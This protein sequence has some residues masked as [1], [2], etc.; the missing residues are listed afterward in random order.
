M[1]RLLDG[2]RVIAPALLPS[3]LGQAPPKLVEASNAAACVLS[4]REREVLERLA[5]GLT[6]REIAGELYVGEETVKSHLSRLYGKLQATDRRD[7]VARA[8]ALGLLG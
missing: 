5:Q 6:N 4:Q 2:E 8:L 7:A 3:L 1:K